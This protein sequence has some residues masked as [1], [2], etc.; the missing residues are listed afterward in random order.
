MS[1]RNNIATLILF[2]QREHEIIVTTV[3]HTMNGMFMKA[4]LFAIRCRICVV[5]TD[6]IHAAKHIFNSSIHPH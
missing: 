1:T 3:Y 4:E 2:I 5:I 6:T